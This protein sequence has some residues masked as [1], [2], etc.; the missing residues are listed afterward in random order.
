MDQEDSRLNLVKLTPRRKYPHLRPLE[1]D[2]WTDFLRDHSDPQLHC[3]YDVHV[4]SVPTIANNLPPQIQKHIN[5]VYPKKID[6]V[7]FTNSRTAIIEIK[8]Y[9][10]LSAIG[11]ALSYTY[12]F[13]THFPDLPNPFPCILTDTP[14]LDMPELCDHFHIRLLTPACPLPF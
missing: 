5:A 7:V 3:A 10:G 9:A 4:G 12:L 1:I 8:P 13:S 11:Q 2:I 6:V 14:Q